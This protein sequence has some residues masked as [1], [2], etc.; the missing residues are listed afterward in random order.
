MHMKQLCFRSLLIATTCLSA[1]SVWAQDPAAPVDAAPAMP[2]AEPL[3]APASPEASDPVAPAPMA[4]AA[5]DEETYPPAWFRID[6]D[7]GGLQLWAGA[8]HPLSD[9]VGLATD[10]YVFDSVG[11]FDIGPAF[12]AGPFVATPMLGMQFNWAEK[13]AWSLVPQFYLTGGPDPIYTELWVQMFLNS[14]FQEDATNTLYARLFVDYKLGKYLA[15]GPQVET[16]LALNGDGD[17]LA[18]LPIGGSV[19]LSNYGQGNSLFLFLGYETQEGARGG[20]IESLDE[21]G[22]GDNAL[23]GRLSFVKNF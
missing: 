22:E 18:S 17:T 14:V 7:L 13:Q 23:V 11:E 20:V 4:D 21:Q 1:G 19:M 8:T 3:P 12:T 2:A 5:D 6:S 15:I 9:T 10:I 16:T